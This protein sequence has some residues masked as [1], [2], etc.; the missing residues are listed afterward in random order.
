VTAGGTALV[1]PQ[2]APGTYSVE[3]TCR[4]FDDGGS[5]DTTGTA[6]FT[7]VAAPQPAEFQIS[8]AQAHPGDAITG[9][10]TGYPS[11]CDPAVRVAGRQV[12]VTVTSE[13][14]P[15]SP[16]VSFAL[17]KGLRPG[18]VGVRLT[19]GQSSA[20]TSLTVLAS[21]TVRLNR[22]EGVAGTEVT[23]IG[24][25]YPAR[26]QPV[27]DIDGQ[28]A[29]VAVRPGK[30]GSPVVTFTVPK[31]LQPGGITVR[32][33]CGEAFAE[34]PFEVLPT[35]APSVTLEPGKGRV[36]VT[37]TA[38]GSQF[39]SECSPAVQ[40]GGQPVPVTVQPGKP[41]NPV[42]SFTVPKGL[43]PGRTTVRLTCGQV[44]AET[45]FQVLVPTLTLEPGQGRADAS[46]AARGSEFPSE[47]SPAVQVAGQPV[48]VTVQ[49]G[50]PG[51]PVVSFSMPKDL[52][53]GPIAVRLTCG[54]VFA[55]APFEVLPTPVPTLTLEP[56]QGRVEASVT[57]RGLDFPLQ[58]SPAALVA[59]QPVPVTTQSASRPGRPVVSFTLSRDLQPGTITIR[60][61][62]GEAF[63]EARFEVLPTPVPTV[64]L[65]PGQA[66]GGE[67]VTVRGT[68]Y[69]PGCESTVRVAG[70]AV[71][72]TRQPDHKPG[73]PVL[74]FTVPND[75]R[76]G[77]VPVRLDCGPA[78]VETPLQLLAV[79][80]AGPVPPAVAPVPPTS[81]PPVENPARPSFVR[82]LP[83]AHEVVWTVDSVVKSLAVFLV[84]F[85][86]VGFPAELFNKTLEENRDRLPS[87]WRR[88]PLPE[89]ATGSGWRH[90]AGYVLGSAVLLSLVESGAGFNV[91]TLILAV[92][93]LISVPLTTL[94]YSGSAELYLQRVDRAPSSLRVLP[95]ALFI[96]AVCVALSRVAEFQPGYSYGL[97][98][99]FAIAAAAARR[100]EHYEG[101]SVVVGATA[102]LVTG[103][104][105][106]VVWT[107]VDE[108]AARP[109]ASPLVLVVDSVLATTFV[110]ALQGVA[111]G[112]APVEYMDGKKLWDW[113]KG[114]W[115]ATWGVSV[116]LFVHVLFWKFVREWK[117][118]IGVVIAAVAPFVLFGL[119]S[120]GLWIY[121]RVTAAFHSSSAGGS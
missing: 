67:P 32:L 60:L 85:F 86:I 76:P 52:R 82:E 120:V 23:A 111:F 64:V 95:L 50:K 25:N 22:N 38:R 24:A 15:G 1:V 45:S 103:V 115:A 110:L 57:A 104:A 72:V 34:A 99:F 80:S 47:C 84:L 112:L 93:F 58:C 14:K 89:D 39:P 51:S 9:R 65:E 97:F 108:V 109:D 29:P 88:D 26:C 106:W 69:P 10:G 91:Q 43:Q 48:P 96:A 46:V 121:L 20:Q 40:V 117:G 81:T 18:P 118:D 16:V 92:A 17:P 4:I 94:A 8:P 75:L 77:A 62:C 78:V 12:P 44:A 101:A 53:P 11:E 63:A 114:M 41:G 33:T 113:R 54:G 13:G 6:S 105:A 83:T 119:I 49:P 66:I 59:G 30:P 90:L 42:V 79:H 37:V 71:P 61:T 27:L 100:R 73:S 70:N 107:P 35:P 21:P 19:C 98:A 7:V 28:S 68:D 3:I 116:F 55:E 56:G 74:S 102:L 36:E 31:G 5:V 87:W 2:V